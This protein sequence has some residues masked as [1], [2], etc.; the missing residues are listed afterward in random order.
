MG[1]PAFFRWLTV[2]YPKVV[3][4]ALS[5]DDLEVFAEEYANEQRKQKNKADSNEIDLTEVDDVEKDLAMAGAMNKRLRDK[6]AKEEK[7][8]SNNPEIDNLYLDMNGIIHPCSHPQNGPQPQSEEEIFRNVYEYTDKVINIVKPQKLIYFAIDG[9]APRAKMN[10]QRAR[11]FRAAKDA[12]EQQDREEAVKTNWANHIT[13]EED[14]GGQDGW[15]FDRNVITPGTEFM[16]RLAKA[17]KRYILEKLNED[18]VWKGLSIVFSD[19]FVPGEGEHKIL[20]FIRSQR[21]FESFNPNTRH[22][23]YG[24]DADLIMLGLSTHEPHFYILR[25]CVQNTRD[26]KCH[27]C[28]KQG[29]M[30]NE[31]G[32]AH[33]QDKTQLAKVA[34][35]QYVKIAVLREYLLLEFKDLKDKLPF[36]FD[37]EKRF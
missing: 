30:S 23:I 16:Y 31:C 5:E 19:A 37:F 34:E 2:R 14:N 3:I 8:R 35:F 21:A 26:I 25:E 32:A 12:E 36:G 10:Q 13:F 29:H 9:V 7:I 11:R 15:H 4:D 22:C 20:D 28:G 18:G 6:S 27:K 33:T 17:L 1:V 24:A